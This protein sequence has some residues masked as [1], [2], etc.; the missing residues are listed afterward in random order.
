MLNTY[1]DAMSAMI[2]RIN[3]GLSASLDGFPHYAE[4]RTGEWTLTPDGFWTGGYWVGE[5][6]LAWLAT[7]DP[8]YKGAAEQ[9]LARLG[10]RIHSKTVFR[11]F[12]FLH[13]AA[14][15]ADLAD[16]KRGRAFAIDSARSLAATFDE[17]AGLMP[18][19]QDAEEAH[20]VSNTD[21]NIDGLTA[22]PLLLWAADAADDQD[23][24]RVALSHAHRN[25]HYCML[26]D[27]R[28]IQSASFNAQTG[29]ILKRF[30]HKGS[31][32]DSV[33]TRAQGW[34]MLGY[35]VCAGMAPEDEALLQHAV[36]ATDWW[37]A[38]AP[39]DHVAYWD[40]DAAQA[41]DTRRDTS[42]TAIAASALLKLSKLVGGDRADEY[43]NRGRLMVE[44]LV[45]HHLQVGKGG[46]GNAD[47]LLA[48]G[49]F[50]MRS[51]AGTS[52]ELIWGSYYLLESLLVLRGNTAGK[53]RI[54]GV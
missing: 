25:A 42:G 34:A 8:Q 27:G 32:D 30:T 53:S 28:V 50:D 11:G 45:E 29:E 48:D 54:I 49:C 52:H 3:A 14:L 31:S 36:T 19:G 22:S 23:L 43:R 10:N 5:L 9:W 40:F 15:G 20:T 47:G 44:A 4:P 51:G 35:A 6:W 26:D 12:L 38:H 1:D 24:R 18:L 13:A 39:A 17:S 16:S 2:R 37:L 21:T 7:H 46:K 41:G 33:W